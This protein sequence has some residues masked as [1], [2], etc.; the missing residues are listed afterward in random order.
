MFHSLILFVALL[1]S[2]CPA[3]HFNIFAAPRQPTPAEQLPSLPAI[4]IPLA[5]RCLLFNVSPEPLQAVATLFSL[6]N[7]TR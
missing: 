2:A 6:L 3:G 5:A 4:E 7:S 1:T